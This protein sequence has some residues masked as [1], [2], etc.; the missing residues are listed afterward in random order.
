MMIGPLLGNFA[1]D[2]FQDSE[3]KRFIE[4]VRSEFASEGCSD[5]LRLLD[6]VIMTSIVY[7]E[8]ALAAFSESIGYGGTNYVAFV[9]RI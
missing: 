2:I 1:G 9:P 5:F 6:S 7:E 3:V 8:Y 4:A